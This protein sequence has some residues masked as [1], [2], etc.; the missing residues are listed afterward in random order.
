[1]PEQLTLTP[2]HHHDPETS[3]LA[4]SKVDAVTQFNRVLVALYMLGES[5]DDELA[6]HTGLL[7]NSAGTRRGKCVEAGLVEHAGFATNDR[8]NTCRTWRLTPDGVVEAQRL[9]RRVA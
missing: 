2:S 8:G 9:A 3:R 5:T 4:A 1:M 7:R 6:A